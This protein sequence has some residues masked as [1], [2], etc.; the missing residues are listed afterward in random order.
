MIYLLDL[1]IHLVLESLGFQQILGVPV[2]LEV[3]QIHPLPGV[4][5]GPVALGNQCLC[6][7][8]DTG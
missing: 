1:G 6:P 7:P 4:Q 3:P 5:T 2:R 8:V